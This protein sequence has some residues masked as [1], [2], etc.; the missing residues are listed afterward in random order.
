M[1]LARG[2]RPAPARRAVH[3][4]KNPKDK[5]EIPIITGVV[6]HQ[7]LTLYLSQ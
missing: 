2:V 4:P 1:I 6:I 5:V 3:A 7:A